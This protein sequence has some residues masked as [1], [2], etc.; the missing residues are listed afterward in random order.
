MLYIRVNDKPIFIAENYKAKYDKPCIPEEIEFDLEMTHYGTGIEP[1]NHPLKNHIRF[2]PCDNC[3]STNI[4]VIFAHWCVSPNSGDSYW[5]YESLCED[6]QK[7]TA[8]SF[9]END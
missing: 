6:C 3:K 2:H 8:C 4:K 9:S 5:D 1:E 7:Y